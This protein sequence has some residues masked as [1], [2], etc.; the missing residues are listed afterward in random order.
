MRSPSVT[1]IAEVVQE[2]LC[3]GCGA[4][5]YL[6]PDRYRMVD[7]PER[8]R[9]PVLPEPDRPSARR[10][11]AEGLAVCP[12]HRLEREAHDA[13]ALPRLAAAWGPVLE[14]FEGFAADPG[15]RRAGSSGGA[16]TALALYCLEKEGMHGV[17]HTAARRDEPVL[18]ETVLSRTRDELL[19][20]TG[21]RYAPASPCEGLARVEAAPAPCVFVGKP[22]DVAAAQR[23]RRVRPALDARLGLVVA[24]FCAGT[25]S[26]RGTTELLRRVGVEDPR[27]VRS[28]RY[29]GLGWPGRFAARVRASDGREEI[30][31]L[32]YADC[33]DF[34][35]RYRPRRCYLC[36]DHTGEL[37][38]IAVGDPWHRPPARGEAGRS[39]VVARTER[40][41][42]ILHAA[43][44][45]GYLEL[46]PCEAELL[47][48]S[49]PELLR[50]R[51]ELWGR[52]M[53]A[54]LA[55]H[56]VPQH[57]GIPLFSLWWRGTGLRAKLRWLRSAAQLAMRA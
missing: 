1:A 10:A 16:S 30:R 5:A 27:D 3:T 29:R 24:F 9:R 42:R 34:L 6:A 17:L 14:V 28:L 32:G 50:A 45:S 37:A 20:A 31:S 13:R 55:G 36:P 47:E 38:D 19:A 26:T 7:D 39:L 8:G 48:R 15:V 44:R 21:S 40:G 35:Q 51:R 52:R 12:G 56:R 43:A 22:C 53:L 54:R 33:W 23:T 4:C 25:P 49:Q 18:N 41:R 2:G 46:E 11:E 57:R